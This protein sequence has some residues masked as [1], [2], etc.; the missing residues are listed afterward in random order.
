[1]ETREPQQQRLRLV[2]GPPTEGPSP[3]LERALEVHPAAV[4]RAMVALNVTVHDEASLVE[5]FDRAAR[6][7]RDVVPGVRWASVTAQLGGAPFTAAATDERA[8]QLDGCQ[9]AAD[10]GP[11]L[12]AMREQRVVSTT[13]HDVQGRW[14]A[15]GATAEELGAASFLAAPLGR[16]PGPPHG[17]LNLYG[18]DARPFDEDAH[19]L[20]AALSESVS[21]GL[22]QF[23]ALQSATREVGQLKGAMARRAVIEQ[24]KGVLMTRLRIGADE[25]FDRLRATSQRSNVK[26]AVV[27]ADVVASQ[28]EPTTV[29]DQD[30][31]VDLGAAGSA[32]LDR[33]A[34]ALAGAVP[35]D[36]RGAFRHAPIGMAVTDPS[37]RVQVVNDELCRL[38]GR[39][40]DDLVGRTMFDATHPDDLDPARAACDTLARTDVPSITA[41]VRLRRSDGTA[42]DASISTAKILGADGRWSSLVMHV[43]D[44][45]EQRALTDQL[46][47]EALHDALT[48]LPNRALLL[49]RLTHA[50][51]R[52]QR[53]SGAV[54]VLYIDL[55][56]FKA[57]ND[58][59]GH[60]A[61]DALL[62]RVAA[63][64]ARN[65]RPS[66]TVARVGGDEFVVLC[67]D[68]E[69]AGARCL[70]ARVAAEVDRPHT[71]P[72]GTVQ[73][74]ASIGVAS[75]HGPSPQDPLVL[76]AEADLAM[77]AVKTPRRGG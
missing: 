56:G 76:L 2:A 73:V 27:A 70:A 69:E 32:F 31:D 40:A 19:D 48:G 9:Y 50:T 34:T 61:G 54:S 15:L 63:V 65:V 20:A 39:P 23:R 11:C 51:A 44:V 72:F 38:L 68:T 71:L 3:Q 33:T 49:D 7:A 10:D 1:M 6:V 16:R 43:Q 46:R 30:A 5:L 53:D 52:H 29:V 67:D 24:A 12:R 75:T 58:T 66:D 36:Y 60:Q 59:F 57:V 41:Q 22:D 74:R 26:L 55:D 62:T 64:L 47:R 35:V 18:G 17:S 14:P 42:F 4:A 25:A 13:R 21:R 8:E 45:T 77:Y 37:G 28:A